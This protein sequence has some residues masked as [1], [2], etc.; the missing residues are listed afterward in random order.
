[1][2]T[3]RSN[4]DLATAAYTLS[5]LAAIASGDYPANTGETPQQYAQRHLDQMVA[6]GIIRIEVES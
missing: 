4:D 5:V 3:Y 6:D 2:T 1:M